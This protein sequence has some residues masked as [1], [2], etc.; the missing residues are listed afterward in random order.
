[1]IS[2]V[3]QYVIFPD[4]RAPPAQPWRRLGAKRESAG[5][6]PESSRRRSRHLPPALLLLPWQPSR[7]R[8]RP[9]PDPRLAQRYA[10]LPHHLERRFRHRNGRLREPAFLGRH[11]AHRHLPRFR[12]Q[13]RVHAFLAIDPATGEIKWRFDMVR[14]PSGGAMTTAGGLV[15]V[16]DSFGNLNA[17]DARTGKVLWRFQTGAPISA[18]PVSYT[19]EGKQYIAVAAGSAVLTFALP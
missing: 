19:F 15:F 10:N 11:L 16:S 5:R 12:R 3:P 18:P 2:E 4:R 9:E 1:M 8:P 6:R 14:P 13:E 17:F 7:W